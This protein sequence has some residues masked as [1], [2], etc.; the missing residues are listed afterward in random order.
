MN[1]LLRL[2]IWNRQVS[3]ASGRISPIQS[4]L[5]ESSIRSAFTEERRSMM[6]DMLCRQLLLIVVMNHSDLR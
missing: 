6:I 2:L 1:K 3:M 5:D 4:D